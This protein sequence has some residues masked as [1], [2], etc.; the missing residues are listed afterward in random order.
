MSPIAK[1][2]AFVI[3]QTNASSGTYQ[4]GKHN[5]PRS[6]HQPCLTIPRPLRKLNAQLA[7]QSSARPHRQSSASLVNTAIFSIARR[8]LDEGSAINLAGMEREHQ[9]GRE[10]KEMRIIKR[11]GKS[12][13]ASSWT[14]LELFKGPSV[15]VSFHRL[16]RLPSIIQF[17]RDQ[18]AK[19]KRFEKIP[20]LSNPSN[21]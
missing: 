12:E 20:I 16:K 6:S 5:G 4:R 10:Q 19:D 18:S 7:R 9:R 2:S 17:T 15:M 21:S 1:P 3:L 8:T 13:E 11:G 14:D